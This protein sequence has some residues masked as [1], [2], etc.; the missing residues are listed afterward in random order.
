MFNI[1]TLYPEK[2]TFFP[3]VQS[4]SLASVLSNHNRSKESCRVLGAERSGDLT[5]VSIQMRCVMMVLL[6]KVYFIVIYFISFSC[7]TNLCL[8]IDCDFDMFVCL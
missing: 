1:K 7:C 8:C 5:V 6:H 2:N 3:S 4:Y